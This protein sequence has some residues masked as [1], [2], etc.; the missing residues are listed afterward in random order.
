M[1]PPK[2]LAAS[3]LR[4]RQTKFSS[5][6][7]LSAGRTID[8]PI[9]RP[10]LRFYLRH[11]EIPCDDLLQSEAGSS[12]GGKNAVVTV[13]T[14]PYRLTSVQPLKVI[15]FSFRLMKPSTATIALSMDGTSEGRRISTNM[16]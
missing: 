5:D 12:G 14:Q 1:P 8:P 3:R 10:F 4:H 2:V 15:R 6:R 11:T 7:G 9:R 13:D 16:Q